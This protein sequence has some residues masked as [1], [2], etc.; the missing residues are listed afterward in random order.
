M[1][2]RMLTKTQA[3]EIR[4]SIEN[5]G[6]S[7]PPAVGDRVTDTRKQKDGIVQIA[8]KT[9]MSVLFDGDEYPEASWV[10]H[11]RRATR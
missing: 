2:G 3:N 10:L 8:G 5:G 9:I 1:T 4:H 7:N 6:V 11:L